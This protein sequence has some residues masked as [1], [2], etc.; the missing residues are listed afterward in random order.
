MQLQH[1]GKFQNQQFLY[2]YYYY[3]C[4]YWNPNACSV[5]VPTAIIRNHSLFDA[6]HCAK[7]SPSARHMAAA[8]A[9]C[10]LIDTFSQNDIALQFII[11]F[12]VI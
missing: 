11:K 2:Y 4:Y 8:N 1:K 9:V 6:V 7:A 10:R 12:N 3:Y 5:R